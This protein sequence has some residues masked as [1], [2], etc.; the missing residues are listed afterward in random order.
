MYNLS[1][2]DKSMADTKNQTSWKIEMILVLATTKAP[3]QLTV[4]QTHAI[5]NATV[6]AVVTVI[7]TLKN[8]VS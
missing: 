3:K 7:A 6:L 4:Q 1:A 5:V 8:V 2:F